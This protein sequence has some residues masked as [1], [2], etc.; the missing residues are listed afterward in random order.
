MRRRQ[1]KTFSACWNSSI[2]GVE[3]Q[4]RREGRREGRKWV[5]EGDL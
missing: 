5:K 2:E 4:A 1:F 3:A